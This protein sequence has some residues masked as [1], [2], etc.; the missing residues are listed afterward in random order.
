MIPEREEVVY[1]VMGRLKSLIPHNG[2]SR[3][4]NFH[5]KYSSVIF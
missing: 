2:L 3:Q 5:P 4:D 1:G